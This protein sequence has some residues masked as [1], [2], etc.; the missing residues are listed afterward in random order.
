MPMATGADTEGD[1][2]RVY[3]H[4]SCGSSTVMPAE[5]VRR[6]QADPW[7][8]LSDQTFCTGCNASVPDQ[9]C[10]WVDTGENLQVYFDRLR[11]TTA[12]RQSVFLLV[13]LGLTLIAIFGLGGGLIYAG[14]AGKKG[15][16]TFD[17]VYPGLSAIGAGLGLIGLLYWLSR[18]PSAE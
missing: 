5:V 1:E 8:Y 2:T 16:V 12:P 4:Q 9:E 7:H 10:V 15:P 14:V 6:Y 11:A 18:P 17:D 3:V 13:K